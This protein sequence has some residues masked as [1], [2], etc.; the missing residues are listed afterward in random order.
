M[1]K[2]TYGLYDDAPDDY[3]DDD[4]ISKPKPAVQKSFSNSP[5]PPDPPVPT[6]PPTRIGVSLPPV[7]VVPARPRPDGYG[8][9]FELSAQVTGQPVVIVFST[10]ERLIE[11]LGRYQPWIMTPA[12]ELSNLLGT[13][14]FAVVLDP[15]EK[16]CR[17]QWTA[18]RLRALKEYRP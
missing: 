13:T 12:A 17:V 14:A 3:W 4:Q 2:D 8:A 7:V 1:P 15:S 18:E 16:V 9:Y 5:S 10:V 11:R 6:E